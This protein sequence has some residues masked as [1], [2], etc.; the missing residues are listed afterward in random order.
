MIL[1]VPHEKLDSISNQAEKLFDW[2]GHGI[3]VGGGSNNDLLTEFRQLKEHP[4][5]FAGHRKIEIWN[6]LN[7][8]VGSIFE[9]LSWFN[10]FVNKHRV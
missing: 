10:W 3:L 4:F 2:M 1:K 5:G 8:A 6:G 9:R 7:D